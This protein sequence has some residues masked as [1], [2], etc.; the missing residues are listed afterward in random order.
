M[1][2]NKDVKPQCVWKYTDDE[3]V[4]IEIIKYVYDMWLEINL[5]EVRYVL[6]NWAVNGLIRD[7]NKNIKESNA[8]THNL[9]ILNEA[10]ILELEA[11]IKD[12]HSSLFYKDKE[13]E[14][15]KTELKIKRQDINR[16]KLFETIERVTG[17]TPLES[18]MD[19]IQNAIF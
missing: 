8:L 12:L 9:N 10:K 4:K 3:N 1:E 15:L 5:G 13:I 14:F 19:E 7:W 17:F 16:Q 6:P 11:Y 18:D 2:V